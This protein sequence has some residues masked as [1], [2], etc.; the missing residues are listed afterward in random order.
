MG[1]LFGIIRNDDIILKDLT[2]SNEESPG[3]LSTGLVEAWIDGLLPTFIVLVLVLSG[4]HFILTLLTIAV[5][6]S[7]DA[8]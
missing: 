6:Y 3:T 5:D 8:W 2:A 1:A 7:R 4:M